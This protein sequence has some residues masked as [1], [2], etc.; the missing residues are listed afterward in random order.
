MKWFKKDLEEQKRLHPQFKEDDLRRG[1]VVRDSEF[2]EVIHV[3]S[4]HCIM[5][6]GTHVYEW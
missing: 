6:D 3:S 2:G 4:S 1:E 5:P